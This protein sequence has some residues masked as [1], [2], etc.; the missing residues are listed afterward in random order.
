MSNE[1]QQPRQ[2]PAPTAVHFDVVCD[3][4]NATPIRG[5]RYSS[6][7]VPNFDLC[8]R[9][10]A[11]G[12]WHAYEPFLKLSR[13]P[14]QGPHIVQHKSVSMRRG[15][16]LTVHY[17]VSCDGC[18]ASPIHGV[19]YKSTS[20]PNFDL[21][22]TCYSS[23]RWTACGPFASLAKPHN[24]GN[25]ATALATMMGVLSFASQPPRNQMPPQQRQQMLR[26]AHAGGGHGG[27]HQGGTQH[28][29]GASHPHNE[30]HDDNGRDDGDDNGAYGNDYTGDD[31]GGFN[32][33]YN[34]D[35]NEDGY[36]NFDGGYYGVDGGGDVYGAA[37][38]GGGYGG[39]DYGG[40]D[41]GGGDY[42]GGDY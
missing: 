28:P 11:T 16:S 21:C 2:P 13:P 39:G 4:C 17:N 41:Y 5:T 32:V 24:E 27:N 19:R 36:N 30:G 9:C 8:G 15:P 23:A 25:V 18:S 38:Y 37:D 34:N 35:G 42:G 40:G 10:E 14:S 1:R 20:L 3:G 22:G 6:S 29:C 31:G 12:R 7:R 26:P 33:G